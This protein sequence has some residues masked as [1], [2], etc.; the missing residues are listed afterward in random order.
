MWTGERRSK[1]PLCTHAVTSDAF[2]T[3]Y[4]NFVALAAERWG[5][6][7]RLVAAFVKWVGATF[8]MME[9]ER[10]RS[11]RVLQRS[12]TRL[13]HQ[14]LFQAQEMLLEDKE[15]SK[16]RFNFLTTDEEKRNG[17]TTDG[18]LYFGTLVECER[19]TLLWQEMAKR[20][21]DFMH[22]TIRADY[23]TSWERWRGLVALMKAQKRAP[24]THLGEGHT[25]NEVAPLGS[26]APHAD[27][28]PW[29]PALGIAA[30]LA[31]P[32]MWA[33]RD[34]MGR[35]KV[36]QQQKFNSF[37][38]M[39]AGPT[40]T[41]NWVI[42]GLVMAGAYVEG[43]ARRRGRQPNPPSAVGQVLMA[44]VG[45]FVCLM[46]GKEVADFERLNGL[47]PLEPELQK[48]FRTIRSFLKSTVTR[49][50]S[51]ASDARKQAAALPVFKKSDKRYEAAKKAMQAAVAKERIAFG[52]AE[53][54]KLAFTKFPQNIEVLQ[55]PLGDGEAL[56][57]KA[58]AK[59]MED[60]EDRLRE[61]RG[62]YLMSRMGHGRACMV[63]AC[64]LGRLYGVRPREAL[65]RIQVYHDA[66]VAVKASGRVIPAPQSLE[67][68]ACVEQLLAI[69][70]A[71]YAPTIHRDGAP[72][73]PREVEFV[74][75]KLRGRGAP[76]P[77][78]P[79][80][81]VRALPSAFV[82]E[83]AE[84]E[85][86]AG[87]ISDMPLVMLPALSCPRGP[88]NRDLRVTTAM[89]EERPLK[90][91]ESRTRE[92]LAPPSLGR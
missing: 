14:S 29:H 54:A 77:L 12:L 82:P 17:F 18:K 43:K 38:A 40:D 75:P 51:A 47:P 89:L 88:S 32:R 5:Y 69:N 36:E 63:G 57:P 78:P 16:W 4:S 25:G 90:R 48:E 74:F 73:N 72:T 50:Q 19:F 44:G 6:E 10:D 31:L 68:V 41:A 66:R 26:V 84:E 80:R 52:G 59:L 71:L 70:E 79:Q 8:E 11:A 33:H 22:R 85:E 65:E 39:I 58:T 86:V 46:G 62:V 27:E 7:Q 60:V 61:G 23:A 81:R 9:E 21:L 15:R 83:A 49:L 1:R 76:V 37:E 55:V 20:T 64:V 92:A 45:T 35:V 28:R 30:L 24:V 53:R 3:E 87:H 67:Q 2:A 34:P 56:S 13:A 42:P 91:G